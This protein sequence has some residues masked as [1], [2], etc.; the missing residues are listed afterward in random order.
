MR[1]WLDEDANN[2]I[3]DNVSKI[4]T[5]VEGLDTQFPA[6]TTNVVD[7][8]DLFISKMERDK[9]TTI[10]RLNTD[11]ARS[12]HIILHDAFDRVKKVDVATDSDYCTARN[13]FL[14]VLQKLNSSI[15]TQPMTF[16]DS[17]N[18][19]RP[20]SF[21]Q[22][23]RKCSNN[24]GLTTE[25]L[26]GE[27]FRP[28]ES[29]ELQPVLERIKRT[30]IDIINKLTKNGNDGV[31]LFTTIFD[32]VV[33]ELNDQLKSTSMLPLTEPRL[34]FIIDLFKKLKIT[35]S[36]QIEDIPGYSNNGISR[37]C[38]IFIKKCSSSGNSTPDCDALRIF[39]NFVDSLIMSVLKSPIIITHK[40]G[41][42][43]LLQLKL[44]HIDT[45]D[46]KYE[47]SMELCRITHF[48]LTPTTGGRSRRKSKTTRGR[49]HRRKTHRKHVR[50]T[51]H[52]RR[53][54][55]ASN[56]HKRKRRSRRR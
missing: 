50:K 48:E 38:V 20:S 26:L 19:L 2:L 42:P 7:Y 34:Q 28:S 9:Q 25:M 4:Q 27:A 18:F 36:L 22:R 54:R 46:K 56:S 52:G 29:N 33:K 45:P 39:N 6:P 14:E 24:P 55:R 35:S 53:G 10:D 3:T 40:E 43:I 17:S 44:N 37:S 23:S 8:I 49:K 5:I 13:I 1:G 32:T 51:M 47:K 15:L 41:G 31:S 16:K 11:F 21:L 12:N 30:F